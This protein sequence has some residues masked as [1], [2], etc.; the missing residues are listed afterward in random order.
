[1]QSINTIGILSLAGLTCLTQPAFAT[2]GT[3]L[4]GY[5]AKAQGMGGVSLAFPQ[6]ALSAANN[7][8]GMSAIGNRFDIGTQIIG[9]TTDSYGYGVFN[10]GDALAP[11]MEFGANWQ[12]NDRLTFGISTAGNGAALAYDDQIITGDSDGTEGMFAGVS[13]LPTVTYKISDYVAIGASLALAAQGLELKNFPGLE[14]HGM[15]FA[16]GIGGRVGALWNASDDLA[17][18]ATYVLKTK[19]SS[20]D[21]YR[22]DLLVSVDGKLDMPE[23]YG[24]GFAYTVTPQ[25]TIGADY[26]H[27]SWSDTQYNESFGYR[28]Q[29]VFRAGASYQLNPDWM[30]RGGASFARRHISSEYVN[31]NLLLSGINSNSVSLGATKK[32]ANGGEMT[33]GFEYDYGSKLEGTGASSGSYIDTEMAIVSLSYGRSF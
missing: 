14:N 4:T 27:I 13:V 12:I 9:V 18:G 26:L 22:S 11:S 17:I 24:T 30:L 25:L 21:D 7:P 5:G 28:D 15:K 16:A 6:D 10:D 2:N 1:M 23:Q 19:M 20:F 8:A 29:D 33:A 31:P 32:L 3:Q